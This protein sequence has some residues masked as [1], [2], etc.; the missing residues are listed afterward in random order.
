[1]ANIIEDMN[2]LQNSYNFVRTEFEDGT[3]KM[4]YQHPTNAGDTKIITVPGVDIE[5]VTI[6]T[7]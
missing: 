2:A 1:M 3:L 5:A 6:E 4:T 7:P